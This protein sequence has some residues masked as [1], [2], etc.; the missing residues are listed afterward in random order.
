MRG[1]CIALIVVASAASVVSVA[2]EPYGDLGDLKILKPEDKEHVKSTPPPTGAMM[3]FN[4]KDFTGWVKTDGK[5]AHW[6][7]VD[8]GAMQVEKGGNIM[9]AQKFDGKFKLHVEFRVPYEPQ[10]KG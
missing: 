7:L 8:G 1:I 6:K 9:T 10:N 3:L 4:G 2:A 5:P